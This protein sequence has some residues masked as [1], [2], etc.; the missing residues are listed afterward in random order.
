MS[1]DFAFFILLF[2]FMCVV[3]LTFLSNTKNPY[4]SAVQVA[5]SGM[6]ALLIANLSAG[7]IGVTVGVNMFTSAFS[8]LLGV[9]GVLVL[10]YLN[11]LIK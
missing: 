7:A 4:I 10:M 2:C 11:F 8:V 3:V 6:I 5:G 9:P 1:I